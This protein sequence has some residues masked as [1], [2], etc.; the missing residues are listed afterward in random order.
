MIFQLSELCIIV[1]LQYETVDQFCHR[2]KFSSELATFKPSSL[3]T[4]SSM[5]L[6]FNESHFLNLLYQQEFQHQINQD[7]ESVIVSYYYLRSSF[8]AMSSFFVAY[9]CSFI[10]LMVETVCLHFHKPSGLFLVSFVC[11]TIAS[12]GGISFDQ[13]E[14]RT[15]HSHHQTQNDSQQHLCLSCCYL[16]LY[17]ELQTVNLC[18]YQTPN[19]LIYHS[20]DVSS[21]NQSL[22]ISQTLLSSLVFLP[23]YPEFQFEPTSLVWIYSMRMSFIRCL[24]C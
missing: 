3:H 20:H 8:Q 13:N 24:H 22:T 1:I 17:S 15:L 18:Y 14:I 6:L 9:H 10:L 16:F 4:C 5:Y 12:L 7:S 23:N 21:F 19:D 11:L 2:C